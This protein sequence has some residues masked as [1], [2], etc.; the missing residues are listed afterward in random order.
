M[1]VNGNYNAVIGVEELAV[2]PITLNNEWT[3]EK[4]DE[5]NNKKHLVINIPDDTNNDEN[6]DNS[7]N[8]DNNDSDVDLEEHRISLDDEFDE[9]NNHEYQDEESYQVINENAVG[10]PSILGLKRAI[11]K[12]LFPSAYP[13]TDKD[14]GRNLYKQKSLT[15]IV[16]D[17]ITLDSTRASSRFSTWTRYQ[18]IQILIKENIELR[19]ESFIPFLSLRELVD[20]LYEG[21]P[22]PSRPIPPNLEELARNE[23]YVS[24]VQNV[25]INRSERHRHFLLM[26]QLTE[27]FG[28]E[29]DYVTPIESQDFN[30]LQN[31]EDSDK[32]QRLSNNFKPFQLDSNLDV[33][34]TRSVNTIVEEEIPEDDS[35]EKKRK[36]V[37]FSDL[38]ESVDFRPVSNKSTNQKGLHMTK[39]MHIAKKAIEF[40]DQKWV[41]P[42]W[43]RAQRDAAIYHPRKGKDLL[44][45]NFY[46]TTTGR[47]C[48]LGGCG[49]QCDPWREGKISEFSSFGPGVSNYFKFLKWSFW[50]FVILT[51]VSFPCLLLN[52]YGPNQY[53]NGLTTLATTTQILPLLTRHQAVISI[54]QAVLIM[55]DF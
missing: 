8:N 47:H 39:S 14:G 23:Y 15:K 46:T 49:E 1:S 48:C 50:L 6:D 16:V 20:Q 11:S 19:G 27:N 12:L 51:L 3:V 54:Y 40:L 10:T 24:K 45:Y 28:N 17:N 5:D 29:F 37:T 41:P 36:S 32:S 42:D 33:H 52:L 2:G 25:W 35:Q 43:E 31:D 21:Y 13:T 4:L 30:D 22:M 9:G 34:V 26:Q 44:P 7:N 38:N 53:L 55:V 18:V